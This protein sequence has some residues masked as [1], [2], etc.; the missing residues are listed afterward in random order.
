M[1]RERTKGA[2]M[3]SVSSQC[4]SSATTAT[5]VRTAAKTA[6]SGSVMV[7]TGLLSVAGG[8]GLTKAAMPDDASRNWLY[9]SIARQELRLFSR[10]EL[11]DVEVRARGGPDQ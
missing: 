4:S 1:L 8:T 7:S 10:E 6:R 5:V 3:T 2:E 9:F 11:L